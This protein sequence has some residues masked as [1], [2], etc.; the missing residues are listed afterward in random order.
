MNKAITLHH[1]VA[2]I[3]ESRMWDGVGFSVWNI[4]RLRL[5]LTMS[6]VWHVRA[7]QNE[8]ICQKR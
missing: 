6:A 4:A 2:G 7:R 8:A 1:R 3:A 5:R